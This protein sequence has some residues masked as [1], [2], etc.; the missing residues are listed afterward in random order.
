MR[1]MTFATVSGRGEME[2]RSAVCVCE[3]N[4]GGGMQVT[5]G[6]K[7]GRRG[8]VAC[9]LAGDYFEDKGADVDEHARGEGK[10]RWKEEGAG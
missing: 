2:R 6:R 7:E 4:V 10:G 5:H 9:G 1:W 3:K 8:Q